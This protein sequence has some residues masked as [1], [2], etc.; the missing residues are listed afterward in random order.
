VVIYFLTVN[1]Y[2]SE[3]LKTL[4]NSLAIN[5]DDYKQLVIVNNSPDDLAVKKLVNH[6]IILL[7]STQNIGFGQ[8]CNLGLNWIYQQNKQAIVW[9]INPDAYLLPDS[10]SKLIKFFTLDSSVSILGTVVNTPDQQVWFAGGIFQPNTGLIDVQTVIDSS[11]DLLIKTPWVTGCSMVINLG[12]FA[13]CP[14]FDPDYFLYYEDFDFCQ[15][16]GKLGHIIA[17]APQISVVHQPSSITSKNPDLK[18][19]YSIYSYLLSLEKHTNRL[20]LWYRLLRILLIAF[21][22]L[23][24]DYHLSINKLKAI[25]KYL[26]RYVWRIS[27]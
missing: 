22:F 18:I 8:A 13:E 24:K 4:I 25:F 6:Q 15:R 9:L 3:L 16:Y 23:P 17:I 26:K 11:K 12:K 19:Q 10:Y 21:L 27:Y 20:V 1:Y 2:S 14:Q 7:E 5:Q